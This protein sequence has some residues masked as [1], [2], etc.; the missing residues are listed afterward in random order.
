MSS[1]H[2]VTAVIAEDE[3]VLREEL[4]SHL[5]SLWPELAIDGVA[6]DGMQALTL[7]E[8]LQPDLV[9]LDIQMP[10]LSGIDV[11]RQISGRCHIVFVTA[12][13]EHAITAFD[14]GAIDYILKPYD[15]L[16]L[17][18]AV[19]RV[20]ARME[21]APAA[22]I[23]RVLDEFTRL[24]GA[25]KF[26]R[27]IRASVVDEIQLILVDDVCFF[28]ADAKYTTVATARGDAVI[29]T[30]LKQLCEELDPDIF[31]NIHRSAIVNVNAIRRIVR[32]PDGSMEV[33]LKDRPERL[34]VSEAH[35]HNFKI[36]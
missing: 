15:L 28:Q 22:S 25:R 20:R 23:E 32:S 2:R 36:M 13:D 30:P 5:K 33:I 11:A 3:A 4:I 21:V 8:K 29:R 10:G 12:Y 27:W 14:Q 35:R 19:E 1:R 26:L 6:K 24:N 31:I 34:P 17:S 7:I 18:R 9:F 16:R